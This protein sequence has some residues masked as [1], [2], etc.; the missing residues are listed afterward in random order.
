[1]FP[2]PHLPCDSAAFWFLMQA[3]ML[4]GFVTKYPVNWWLIRRGSRKSCEARPA[5]RS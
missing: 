2:A 4:I 3:G 1:L 5:A